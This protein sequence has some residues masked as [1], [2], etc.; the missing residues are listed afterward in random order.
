MVVANHI[1]SKLRWKRRGQPLSHSADQVRPSDEPE[2]MS[3]N[4]DCRLRSLHVDQFMQERWSAS[5]FNFR[6]NFFN[7]AS[8]K[9]YEIKSTWNLLGNGWR[10]CFSLTIFHYNTTISVYRNISCNNYRLK[11]IFKW[12]LRCINISHRQARKIRLFFNSAQDSIQLKMYTYQVVFYVFYNSRRCDVTN[13]A[14]VTVGNANNRRGII[15]QS[16]HVFQV[17][18]N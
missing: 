16:G 18:W 1:I 7:A 13:F 11:R 5:P 12:K 17:L 4:V 2:S 9:S 6:H 8:V 15:D 3:A 10:Y 14:V